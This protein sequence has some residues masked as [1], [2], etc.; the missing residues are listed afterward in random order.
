MPAFDL[1][2]TTGVAFGATTVQLVEDIVGG[3]FV[4]LPGNYILYTM[5]KPATLRTKLF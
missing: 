1:V 2:N 5:T 4:G 3:V